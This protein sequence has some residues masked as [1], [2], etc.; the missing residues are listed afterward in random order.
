MLL[1]SESLPRQTH[2]S[3]TCCVQV[4]QAA[5]EVRQQIR[6]RLVG[7]L[8][9]G[10]ALTVLH[11]LVGVTFPVWV[12]PAAAAAAVPALSGQRTAFSAAFSGVGDDDGVLRGCRIQDLNVDLRVRLHIK[13]Q[14]TYKS[15][16]LG[17]E[18]HDCRKCW[19]NPR[20]LPS[21]PVHTSSQAAESVDIML[22]HLCNDSHISQQ[23]ATAGQHPVAG[24]RAARGGGRA[25]LGHPEAPGSAAA[26]AGRHL[27]RRHRCAAQVLPALHRQRLEGMRDC[28][29]SV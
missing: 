6:E 10:G 7:F 13:Q 3:P 21:A 14:S 25:L 5:A 8:Q 22:A 1:T 23:F 2:H 28:L 20:C 17:A 15:A 12:P 11:S 27:E 26:P 19:L 29:H 24:V 18:G 4:S 9:A 16:L